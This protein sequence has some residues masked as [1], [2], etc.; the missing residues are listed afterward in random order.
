[1]YLLNEFAR[2]QGSKDKKQRLKK[3]LLIAGGL[4]AAGLLGAAA[5]KR[6]KNIES[7]N[8]FNG[9]LNNAKI[10]LNKVNAKVQNSINTNTK[11]LDKHNLVKSRQELLNAANLELNSNSPLDFL[12][13]KPSKANQ[14]DR[15]KQV[16]SL[17]NKLKSKS[18]YFSN[19][20][21]NYL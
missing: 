18:Q 1:M 7:S 2:T 3:G 9:E 20:L 4:A 10:Q 11:K 5:I 15:K 14:K 16:V 13:K 19:P 17:V 21:L 8:I 12:M 6:K